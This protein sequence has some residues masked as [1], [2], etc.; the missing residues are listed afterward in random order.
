MSN[1]GLSNV[2]KRMSLMRGFSIG[3]NFSKSEAELPPI[4]PTPLTIDI[5]KIKEFYTAFNQDEVVEKSK[6]VDGLISTE[7]FVL[8]QKLSEEESR[9]MEEAWQV[10]DKIGILDALVD[11]LYLLLG[12]AHEFGMLDILP[13]AFNEVHRSNMTKLENGEPLLREDGKI[14]KG[15]KY[16]KPNIKQF[17]KK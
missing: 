11:R 4:P 9:E 16:E 15:S 14:L 13:L 7:R 12:D 2:L 17:L 3:H 1:F 8:R 6:N 10:S 5:S